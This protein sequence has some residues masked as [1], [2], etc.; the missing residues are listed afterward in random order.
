M[1]ASSRRG[2]ISRLAREAGG[3]PTSTLLQGVETMDC[4]SCGRYRPSSEIA[5]LRE[6]GGRLAMVCGRC[7]RLAKS[8]REPASPAEEPTA[9]VAAETA[10]PAL[11][12]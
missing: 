11:V 9:V 4:D 7:R 5:P 12:R 10:I 2:G 1:L 6:A 3:R 8:R